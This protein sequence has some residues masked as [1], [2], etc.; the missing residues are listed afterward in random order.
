M[1]LLIKDVINQSVGYMYG[2]TVQGILGA[3]KNTKNWVV[4]KGMSSSGRK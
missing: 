2:D 3:W 4:R 1:P